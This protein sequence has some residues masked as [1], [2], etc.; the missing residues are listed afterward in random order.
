MTIELATFIWM[1]AGAYLA[2]GAVVGLAVVFGAARLDHAA[3]GAN[4][5][6]RMT[7]FPGAVALWPFMIGRFL[8]FRKINAPIPGR[9]DGGAP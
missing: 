1:I 3:D 6:F 2:V 5:F 9:E 4:L 7:I 8:S